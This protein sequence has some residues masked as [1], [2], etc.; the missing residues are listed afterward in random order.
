MEVSIFNGAGQAD[1]LYGLVS[2][3]HST[4]LSKIEVVDID[5]SAP[6]FAKFEKVKFHSAF[7]YQKK[8]S[9]LLKKSRNIIRF[10]F[11][12]SGHLLTKKTQV[13]HF[14]WLSRFY[15]TDRILLPVLARL[16]GHKV[17]LTVHN[18]NAGK[19]DNNDTYYNRFTLHM[20]YNLC[21]HLIVHTEKSKQELIEEFKVTPD[22]VSVIKHGM[23][24]K[25]TTVGLSKLEAR[26]KLDILSDRKVVLF[27]GNIDHY[28]GLDLL[29][30]SLNH[31]PYG[32]SDNITLLIAGNIKS[33][34]YFNQIQL[35][36]DSSNFRRNIIAHIKYIEDEDIEQ[37]FAAS[38]C[39]VMPYRD[40]Y[41]SGVLFM[42]YNFGLPIIATDV[43][44]FRNDIIHDKTGMIIEEIDPKS[45]ALKIVEYFDSRMY[46]NI[47]QTQQYIKS[48]AYGE[49]SW[50][51][52]G[53]ET[54]NL[55]KKLVSNGH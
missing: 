16:K 42:A 44:N 33:K 51:T 38:D 41:Q 3:L 2:G 47:A 36:I 10:Y 37:Y 53:N 7:R 50:D 13:I 28:K 6:L 29:I 46:K 55:Y 34:D 27:F 14:Q 49:F 26:A 54:Y 40:I 35:Q 17:V 11:I 31:I 4:P 5:L 39:I 19:R 45:I 43:G 20:L 24:N 1:Y 30:E 25:V 48:W 12:Q 52:I 9:S 8:G 32:L 15:I 21:N 18:V 23:N 22:K